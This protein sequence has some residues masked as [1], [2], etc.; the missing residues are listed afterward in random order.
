MAETVDFPGIRKEHQGKESKSRDIGLRRRFL[1]SPLGKA[2]TV[3]GGL[4]IAGIYYGHNALESNFAE[5]RDAGIYPHNIL[6]GRII[7]T[8]GVRLRE[9]TDVPHSTEDQEVNREYHLEDIVAI[10]SQNM[11]N[12]QEIAIENAKTI[13]GDYVSN[14]NEPDLPQE[15]LPW[16]PPGDDWG[17]LEDVVVKDGF[18][19]RRLKQLYYSFSK[20]TLK[21]KVI[22]AGANLKKA[23]VKPSPDNQSFFVTL[24]NG[25][26]VGPDSVNK[27]TPIGN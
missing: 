20:Q 5:I 18:I 17:V 13:K 4:T 15:I 19:K 2:A 9:L 7:L 8:Q 16:N 3:V 27:I 14:L 23:E 1:R 25:E 11:E 22:L 10:G 26:T 6:E 24:H 21:A 12:V